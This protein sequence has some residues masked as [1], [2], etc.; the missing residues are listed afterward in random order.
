MR[1]GALDVIEKPATVETLIYVSRSLWP[2]RGLGAPSQP[3]L[4]DPPAP[5]AS[6]LAAR[7]AQYA[8]RGI[9][10]PRDLKTLTLWAR[11]VAVSESTLGETCRL[12]GI[13]A[14]DSRDLTRTLRAV[15]VAHRLQCDVASLFDISDLRTLRSLLKRA[16]L[17]DGGKSSLATLMQRQQFVDPNK[18]CFLELRRLLARCGY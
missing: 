4:A 12:N 7:W 11:F 9:Q 1:L 16:G 2:R 10:S 15:V 18:S 13:S 3:A 17:E 5:M 6:S 8:V 14:L